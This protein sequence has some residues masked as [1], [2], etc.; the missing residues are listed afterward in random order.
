MWLCVGHSTILERRYE[1]GPL[2]KVKA[3]HTFH[4]RS[5]H[6]DCQGKSTNRTDKQTNNKYQHISA[7]T[8]QNETI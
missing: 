5:L 7:Y 4:N 3:K 2:T 6:A 8:K 1:P